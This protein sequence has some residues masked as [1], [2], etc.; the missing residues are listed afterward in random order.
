MSRPRRSISS[1]GSLN[2]QSR[3]DMSLG[4]SIAMLLTLQD[5]QS[6]SRSQLAPQALLVVLT[7]AGAWI[8][9]KRRMLVRWVAAA[10]AVA[11]LYLVAASTTGGL[12]GYLTWPWHSSSERIAANLVYFVP[13]FSAIS[14]SALTD[15]IRSHRLEMIGL[16][17]AVVVICASGFA[18]S[19]AFRTD[20]E[21]RSALRSE[22][23]SA[24]RFISEQGGGSPVI[25]NPEVDGA[26]WMYASESLRPLVISDLDADPSF[27]KVWSEGTAHVYRVLEP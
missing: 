3:R 25:A 20:I 13:V 21:F 9:V 23:L 8:L 12:A 2:G 24:F 14:L 4:A 27:V 15:W 17:A 7:V 22:Q 1:V 6:L 26:I 19:D 16:T 11:L 18:L 10:G 5:K